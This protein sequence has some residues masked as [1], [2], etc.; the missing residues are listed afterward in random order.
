MN[1]GRVL[2]R[3]GKDYEKLLKSGKVFTSYS[4]GHIYIIRISYTDQHIFS[5]LMNDNYPF[6]C[7][8]VMINDIHHCEYIQ[9]RMKTMNGITSLLHIPCPCCYNILNSWSPAYY[10]L[11][12]VE[13]HDTTLKMMNIMQK[14][15]YINKFISK[16][17]PNCDNILI[18]RLIYNYLM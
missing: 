5:I 2:K 14:M 18:L 10:L 16:T 8:K 3:L 15:N 12:I 11:N 9:K 6:E 13:E 17:F 4:D 7:P 1:E